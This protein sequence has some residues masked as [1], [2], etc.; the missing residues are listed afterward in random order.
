MGSKRNRP[1]TAA[2]C[3]IYRF[4]QGITTTV[5]GSPEP[6]APLVKLISGATGSRRSCR[7]VTS[8]PLP[9]FTTSAA[10]A[11]TAVVIFAP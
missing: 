7:S 5:P 6:V 1:P 8:A 10:T 11:H 4:A 9:R 2:A 3:L